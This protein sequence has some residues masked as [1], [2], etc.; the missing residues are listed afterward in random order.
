MASLSSKISAPGRHAKQLT[1]IGS[2]KQKRLTR[3]GLQPSA[4]QEPGRD[5]VRLNR[6]GCSLFKNGDHSQLI[7]IAGDK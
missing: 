6:V 1:L 7:A 3:I 2:F 5:A 4:E